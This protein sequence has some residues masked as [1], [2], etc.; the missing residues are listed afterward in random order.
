MFWTCKLQ[1]Y[2]NA[3]EMLH[4]HGHGGLEAG[5]VGNGRDLRMLCV[6]MSLLNTSKGI[7]YQKTDPNPNWV[8]LALCGQW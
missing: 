6:H 4:P 7:H 2:V 5:R 8:Q 1:K 3:E